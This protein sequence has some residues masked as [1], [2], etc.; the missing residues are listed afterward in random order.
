MLKI[1]TPTLIV[2]GTQAFPPVEHL[3]IWGRTMSN[4]RVLLVPNAGHE[5]AQFENPA[6]FFESIET[7]LQ[8]KW[9][10]DA[11]TYK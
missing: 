10:T 5:T 6:Y 2:N 7:F 3:Y 8:G 11:K 9:P 4:A 1:K